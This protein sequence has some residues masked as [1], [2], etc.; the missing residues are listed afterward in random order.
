MTGTLT[1]RPE[2]PAEA[3]R[4]AR[5][6]PATPVS[7]GPAPAEAAAAAA[8]SVRALASPLLEAA[9]LRPQRLGVESAWYGH[10]PFAHWLAAQCRPR[11]L[12]ELGTHYG[13]SYFAFCEALARFG[14]EVRAYA[15]DTWQGDEHAGHYDNRVFEDVRAFHDE[16]FR[17]FSELLRGRFSDALDHFEDGSVDLLHIDGFHTYEAVRADW[18]AWRPKLSDR[19]VVLFHDTNVRERDFGVWR[20]WAELREAHPGF[21]FLHGHGLGVLVPGRNAPAAA[22][23][24]CSLPPAEVAAVR[25]RFALLGERWVEAAERRGNIAAQQRAEAS[26]AGKVAELERAAEEARRLQAEIA[27]AAGEAEGLREQLRERDAEMARHR[28]TQDALARAHDALAA[29]KE[30]LTAA[31]DEQRALREELDAARAGVEAQRDRLRAELEAVRAEAA[32]QRDRQRAELEAVQAERLRE[33][34]EANELRHQHHAVTSSTAWRATAPVRGLGARFPRL[35]R[36]SGRALRLGALAVTGQ[37]PDRLRLRRQLREDAE[38]LRH[39]PLFD[40]QR[41]LARYPDVA[42]SG[43][44]PLWHYLWSGATAGYDPHPLFSSRWYLDQHPGLEAAHVNPLAHYVREGASLGHDPHPVFDTAH[45][46]SQEPEAAGRNPLLHYLDVGAARG[47][48]PNP[49]FDTV[50]YWEEN[51]RDGNTA[52]E[53]LS[54]YVTQGAAAGLDP[55]AL[56]DTD[57][58]ARTYPD[59]AGWN[60]LA[61][62]LREGRA[63]G[64]APC[65]LLLQSATE[66]PPLHFTPVT[67][68]DVSIIVPVYGRLFDTLRCL[69]SIMVH[70]GTGVSYEVIVADDKP[71][72]PTAPRLRGIPGLR[73]EQNPRNLGFLRSC[74]RAAQAATGRYLLFLNND[75]SV[76]P[77]WLA[78]LVQLADADPR[79]GIV[80]SKLLNADGTVQEAGGTIHS[81]GWGEPYGRGDDPDRPQ[82]NFVREVDVAIGAC[83]LVRTAA[84]EEV[85]GFDDR[86]AP[87]YYEEFDLAFALR[88]R[89]WRVLYQPASRVTHF[90]ASSYGAAE[91]D[92]QSMRNHAQFCEKWDAAVAAQPAP[93]TAP[94]VWRERPAPG[95]RIL[96]IDDRVPEPDKHAGSVST[97]HWLRLLREA[98]MRVTFMPHDQDRPEP[99]TAALQQMG[100]EV[101][102]GPVDRAAWLA[103]NG[104]YLDHVWAARPDVAEPLLPAIERHAPGRMIYFTHDLHFL[105]EERRHAL[106][107]NSWSLGESRRLRRI[108]RDIFRRA[109]LVI[110]P[111]A[112][113]V[114]VIR[115]LAPEAQ[116]RDV[117]LYSVPTAPVQRAEAA[118]FAGRDALVFV[119]G[120]AHPPNVDAA[121]WLAREIMP[122]VWH[123]VPEARLLLV[124]SKPPPEVLALAG[125]RVEVPGWVADLDPIYA[126]ARASVSPL[127]YGAGVKGK[128]IA[129]LEAGVPVVTTPIGNEGLGLRDGVEALVGDGAAALAAQAVAL[130]RDPALCARLANGGAALLRRRFD[131]DAARRVLMAVLGR[132][133]CP[134]CGRRTRAATPPPRCERCGAG[135]PERSLAEAVIRPWRPLAVTSLRDALPFLTGM[136]LR[137]PEGPLAAVLEEAGLPL[138]EGTELDLLVTTGPGTEGQV[139]RPGGRWIH[140]APAAPEEVAATLG[141]QGWTVRLHDAGTP[142]IEAEK[143]GTLA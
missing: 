91:R 90:D 70:S 21:E 104:R 126:R 133:L 92:R 107:G 33:Q 23:A 124:G 9:F 49:F 6:T 116:A 86:Y 46:L 96:F 31:Q 7:P 83:I 73:V 20:L 51:I 80:G 26:L 63:R 13:V 109:R 100:I 132:D 41:Y 44:D 138:R 88:D 127:R 101:L 79:C 48:A 42:R 60:P 5:N 98:G 89:G 72:A 128:I 39:T 93:D 143:T 29:A 32:A 2:A 10:V 114:P 28:D 47:H 64:Y 75:T 140:P 87:A 74:N 135:E 25:E 102:Y 24:L 61:H 121:L 50:G 17:G 117:P 11:V 1:Q 139:L 113:E 35:A 4:D 82:Y 112:D 106:D 58:Y 142:V 141:G 40:A 22:R 38:T 77:G 55:H 123:A 120:Y 119:G 18:E 76:H 54:H 15:V 122:I 53:P 108:E 14:V 8:E 12:V 137:V 62:F 71:Q 57:W 105:R 36:H 111:S 56:F 16:R 118:A 130:L 136:R 67:A 69:Y 34:V 66:P 43:A 45:Y 30:E 134:C 68:P 131:E 37:L 97:L 65:L 3:G 27:R 78:P 110:T 94:F 103:E 115:Q 52:F 84:W 95:G 125:E 99:Y 19:A 59:S 81:N 129:A 85:G